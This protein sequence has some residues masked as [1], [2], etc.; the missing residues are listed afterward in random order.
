MPVTYISPEY[1]KKIFGEEQ[2]VPEAFQNRKNLKMYGLDSVEDPSAN[3]PE[4]EIKN[5]IG[6]LNTLLSQVEESVTLVRWSIECLLSARNYEV[7]VPKN[8][9]NCW[10][11]FYK[12]RWVK[13]QP[14]RGKV[15]VLDTET[16]P[17]LDGR[18]WLPF[19]AVA[20]TT[21]TVYVWWGD[22]TKMVPMGIGNIIVA[23]NANYDRSMVDISYKKNDDNIWLDTYSLATSIR[24]VSKQ[25]IGPW[26]ACRNARW[27]KEYPGGLSLKELYK[28]YTGKTLSKDERTNIKEDGRDYLKTMIVGKAFGYCLKDVQAT[29]DILMNL[30][31]EWLEQC[32][33]NLSLKG[34]ILVGQERLPIS[35]EWQDY[36]VRADECYEATLKEIEKVLMDLAEKVHEQGDKENHWFKQLDWTINKKTK[37]AKWF[38]SIKRTGLTLKSKETPLLLEVTYDKHPIV[39]A[40]LAEK[41]S[42]RKNNGF[43][44]EEDGKIVKIENPNGTGTV[45]KSF[46]TKDFSDLLDSGA[47]TSSSSDNQLLVDLLAK[48]RTTV[49]WT[50]TQ[51]RVKKVFT[52]S[53][54]EGQQ[55]TIPDDKVLGTLTRRK[56]GSSWPV[57]SNQKKGRIGT[58][59]KCYIQPPKG[60]KFVQTDVDSEELRLFALL[61]DIKATGIAGSSPL[62]VS[63]LCG[64]K[65]KGNDVHSLVA[66]QL[67][68]SR[69]QA[70][71][72]V[73][74]T[75]YGMSLKGF[76]NSL[77]LANP[78]WSE[79]EVMD[80]ARKYQD[81]F[82]TGLVEG[83]PGIGDGSFK[84]VAEEVR[85]SIPRT[86]ILGSSIPKTLRGT[87]DFTTTRNNWVVQSSGRD[88]L[89]AFV[90]FVDI[91]TNNLKVDMKLF[92]TVHDSIHFL[93]PEGQEEKASYVVAMAHLFAWSLVIQKMGLKTLPKALMYPESI[94]VD[95]MVRKNPQD[96][97]ITGSKDWPSEPGYSLSAEDIAGF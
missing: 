18:R 56:A 84:R 44:Y 90:S 5:Q 68:V 20:Q 86:P 6:N 55:W 59:T 73:Y 71:A 12:G 4:I 91:I 2:L 57:F 14:P 36:V 81:Y 41:G 75:I 28:Y 49:N 63:V 38:S 85:K 96:P 89:D 24:G 61:G 70:K 21:E 97:C 25:Q 30:W 8:I 33:S 15:M 67:G 26:H 72:L 52:E 42:K 10:Q 35:N 94:D 76:K 7:T 78:S 77:S 53:D 79:K 17:S 62:C 1:H 43:G 66:K 83:T 31:P 3:T 22:G 95:T 54:E 50:A 65:S 29:K 23:H 13:C 82:K 74:G 46:F 47:I 58:E 80:K 34:M 11:K 9:L 88:F 37:K 93:V 51:S 27:A 87:T 39:W 48:I 60:Y 92:M 69:D 32:P 40:D 45:V 64:Q 19:L 16:V